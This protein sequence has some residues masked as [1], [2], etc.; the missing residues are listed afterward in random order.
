[1]KKFTQNLYLIIFLLNLTNGLSAQE[2]QT[3]KFYLEI[4]G[5]PRIT[6]KAEFANR[7]N[8]FGSWRY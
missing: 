1:M 5:G 2:R 6:S 7:K 4:G 8:S 3:S